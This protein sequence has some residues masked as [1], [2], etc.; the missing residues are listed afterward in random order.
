MSAI[1]LTVSHIFRLRN[2][3]AYCI[4]DRTMIWTLI[5]SLQENAI[6]FPFLLL[7]AAHTH[8]I[9]RAPQAFGSVGSISELNNICYHL[10]STAVIRAALYQHCVR[11]LP[12]LPQIH[13]TEI[14]LG[15]V[16]NLTSMI[17]KPESFQV[18]G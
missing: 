5:D 18:S 3:K 2:L 11:W 1:A 4:A 16:Q 12:T 7:Y 13:V 6:A 10:T 8:T 17:M 9:F 14:L 15:R